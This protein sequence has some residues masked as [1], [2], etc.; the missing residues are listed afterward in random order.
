MRHL[1]DLTIEQLTG[2]CKERKLPAFRAKQITQWVLK[3]R[4]AS[5]DDMSDLPKTLRAKLADDF[6]LWSMQV[7]SQQQA[8]DGTRKLLLELQD[9][10]RIECVMLCDDRGHRTACISTQVGC[11]MGCV[12]CATGLDG[13]ARNLS[14]GEIL[15][16]LLQLQR[17]LDEDQR[18][19]HVVVMGMGEPLMNLDALLPALDITSSP[20]GLGISARKITISTVGLP[21][22]IYRL[23][24][25][26]APYHLAIS[27]HA[28]DDD[29]RNQLIPANARTGGID[30][31]LRAA[32]QYFR[33]TG[34]R[35]TYEY[36]LLR[37]LND[38][39][40]HA[41]GLADLL[42][43]RNA[44]VNLIPFNPVDGLDFQTPCAND[45]ARFVEILEK[46]GIQVQVRY[47]KGDK[48][49]AACGQLRRRMREAD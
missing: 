37:D 25:H 47:R 6:T 15:E 26:D 14:R 36:V 28:P 27:L 23:A 12:F 41:R 24:D 35:V 22:G 9:G 7:V 13:V 5:F 3:R 42:K 33:K 4:S 38:R 29:L 20:D 11:A 18:L 10:H 16:Q 2:W 30:R 48:I 31:L 43:G 44:L 17:L 40:E 45:V 34:R 46:R 32:D 39:T 8:A 19:S 1:L 49:D 21:K